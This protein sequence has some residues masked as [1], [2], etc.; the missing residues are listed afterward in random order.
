MERKLFLGTLQGALGITKSDDGYLNVL[1]IGAG[2]VPARKTP[3][4]HVWAK[5]PFLTKEG[6]LY[7]NFSDFQEYFL[8]EL[9]QRSSKAEKKRRK[10][11]IS[12]K[13]CIFAAIKGNQTTDVASMKG[14][15]VR[16]RN[17]SCC[18]DPHYEG[19]LV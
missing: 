14:N 10:C 12:Q 16:I 5:K 8:R 4:R 6:I 2:F 17:S 1:T 3:S 11:I 15:P 13:S 7:L 19:L 18:C 9:F